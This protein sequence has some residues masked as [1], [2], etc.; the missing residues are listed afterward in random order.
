[1]ARKSGKD[2]R[3]SA[4]VT[5]SRAR[6]R[7]GL[8]AAR[9]RGRTMPKRRCWMAPPIALSDQ[10]ELDVAVVGRRSCHAQHCGGVRWRDAR[11]KVRS[12][13]DLVHRCHPEVI[14]VGAEQAQW[15]SEGRL[16]LYAPAVNVN[17]L[18]RR[19]GNS[20]RMKISVGWML[21]DYEARQASCW[22][23]KQGPRVGAGRPWQGSNEQARSS[24]SAP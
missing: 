10:P 22:P 11:V 16:D 12:G 23:P 8:S 14:R 20:A 9:S 17:G 18:D 3:N 21:D 1:M 2:F 5:N 4:E 19:Q 7:E 15:V 24:S 6:C 13:V